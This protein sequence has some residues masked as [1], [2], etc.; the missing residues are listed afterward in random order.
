MNYYYKKNFIELKDV[1]FADVFFDNGDYICIHKS[2]IIDFNFEFYDK[3]I[4]N[5]REITPVAKSG[6]VKLKIA[7]KDRYMYKSH[8][9]KTIEEYKRDRRQYINNRCIGDCGITYIR[10]FDNHN[11]HKGVCGQFV[12]KIENDYLILTTKDI[13]PTLS[14]SSDNFNITLNPIKKSII[15]RITL[16]FENCETV[17]IYKDEIISFDLVFEEELN[18]GSGNYSRKL[19]HGYI[20]IKLDPKITWRHNDIYTDNEK[21]TLKDIKKR[22]C[23]NNNK[24]YHDIVRLYIDYEY[25]GFTMVKEEAIEISGHWGNV[26]DEDEFPQYIGGYCEIL[27]GDVISVYFNKKT[28]D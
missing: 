1:E 4:M 26:D 19:K 13:W 10:F 5:R 16:D 22:L 9:M 27:K 23:Y 2:E 14:S 7:K 24:S 17:D 11:W 6:F 3:M 18:P 21:I 25:A 28:L 15:E 8:Y 12:G 20:K